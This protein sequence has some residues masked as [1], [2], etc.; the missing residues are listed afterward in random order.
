MNEIFLET[1]TLCGPGFILQKD[2]IAHKQSC[3]NTI[4]SQP[5]SSLNYTH[6]IF[7]NCFHSN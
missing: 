5:N 6:K 1:S 4:I 7:S 2:F 3:K